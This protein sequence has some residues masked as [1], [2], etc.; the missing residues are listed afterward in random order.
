MTNIAFAI[1]SFHLEILK[2]PY[3][4]LGQRGT[5]PAIPYSSPLF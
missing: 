5:L 3:I 1:N 2:S 4:P